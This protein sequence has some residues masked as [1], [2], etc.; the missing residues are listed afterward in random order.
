MSRTVEV[1]LTP[2]LMSL[3]DVKD[4]VVVV[5]DVLR[6]TSCMVAGLGSGVASI[7]PFAE[8]EACRAMKAVGYRIAGERGGE[9]VEGFDLGNSP[10]EYMAEENQGQKIATTTTNG[11]RAIAL[12]RRSQGVYIGAFLNLTAVATALRQRSEDILILCAGWKGRFNLE[13]TLFAGA[14]IAALEGN[15]TPTD[16]AAIAAL[17]LYQSQQDSLQAFLRQSAHAQRLSGPG[18]ARDIELCL[19]LDQYDVVPVLKGNELMPL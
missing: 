17:S 3:Y 16:D 19:T 11:T 10:Y 9:K 6:A 2:E 5:V 15:A 8:L 1:C 18:A 7:T 14:L 12:S 13:D 4:S